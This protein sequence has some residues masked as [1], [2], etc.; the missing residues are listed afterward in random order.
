MHA[1]SRAGGGRGT[2]FEPSP[3]GRGSLD[4][5]ADPF[6]E[7]CPC[8]GARMELYVLFNGHPTPEVRGPLTTSACPSPTSSHRL[9]RAVLMERPCFFGMLGTWLGRS[10]NTN[11]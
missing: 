5:E 2:G 11:L 9:G 10:D 3:F 7:G 8:L 1:F 4:T 6:G